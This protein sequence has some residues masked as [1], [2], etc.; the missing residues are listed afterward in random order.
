VVRCPSCRLTVTREA[1]MQ[2]DL[3]MALVDDQALEN[4]ERDLRRSLD[5]QR[6]RSYGERQALVLAYVRVVVERQIRETERRL[7][8]RG[9]RR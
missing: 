8:L 3:E 7:G 5:D 1:A 9:R 2:R 6:G 4:A